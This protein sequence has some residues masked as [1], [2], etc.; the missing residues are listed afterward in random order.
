[1]R[2]LLQHS[3]TKRY[4]GRA[5]NWTDDPDAALA[6]LDEVRAHDYSIYRRL[7]EAQVVVRNET[8]SAESGQPAEVAAAG[9][10]THFYSQ[11]LMIAKENA[12]QTAKPVKIKVNRTRLTAEPLMAHQMAE[13]VGEPSVQ[14]VREHNRRRS[15]KPESPG[16]L[17]LVKANIDVGFGNALFIRGQGQGLSWDKGLPLECVDETT[18]VWSTRNEHDKLVF[19]LLIN[20]QTWAK[21][22]DLVVAAGG[23]IEV[24]PA[25]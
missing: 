7:S 4:L 2:I 22:G 8:R 25:F 24:N 10:E 17:T 16:L 13:T 21:G 11:S 5:G 3:Q 1:M 14:P 9:D 19:K 20:D 18:W 15:L 6:F 12:S 23:R